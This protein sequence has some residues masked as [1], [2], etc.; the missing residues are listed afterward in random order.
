MRNDPSAVM[1]FA[2]GFGTRM[3]ELTKNRPKPLLHVAGQTLIDRTLDLVEE[4]A[5]E[6]VVVN[7]HYKAQ[8]MQ[9]H[10]GPRGVQISDEQ[11]EILDTGGGLKAALPILGAGPFFTMNSDAVWDGPNPLVHLLQFWE[12]AKMDALLLCLPIERAVGHAGTNDFRIGPDGQLTR[13][14]GQVYSGLQI[15][16]AQPVSEVEERVFSLREV[17][18]NLRSQGRISRATYPGRWCDVG[19]P[20]GIKLA[21]KMIERPDV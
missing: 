20:E 4:I 5:P 12:P 9:A 21:E 6:K 3:G 16:K 13:G 1:I 14:E 2:A 15:I 17:W 10:L 18:K 11:P 7:T 8:M 19:H